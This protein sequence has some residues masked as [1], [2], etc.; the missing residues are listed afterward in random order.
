MCAVAGPPGRGGPLAAAVRGVRAWPSAP[1]RSFTG[2]SLLV[3]VCV[4][5][6]GCAGE[7][8]RPPG[9]V[10]SSTGSDRSATF[11]A[12]WL[13]LACLSCQP[14]VSLHTEEAVS[15]RASGGVGGMIPLVSWEGRCHLDCMENGGCV[16]PSQSSSSE[17][18]PEHFPVLGWAESLCAVLWGVLPALP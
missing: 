1:V 14:A 4:H 11:P 10:V 18:L 8:P 7:G 5:R 12:P 13:H 9:L 2:S 17:S 6:T 15:E 16:S 3:C